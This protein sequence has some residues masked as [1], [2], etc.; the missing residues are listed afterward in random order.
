M[1]ICNSVDGFDAEI[2]DLNE[3]AVWHIHILNNPKSELLQANITSQR[4]VGMKLYIFNK[5]NNKTSLNYYSVTL[6]MEWC[7]SL[8]RKKQQHVYWYKQAI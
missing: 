1:V 5:N 7:A 6:L 4:K 2:H 3:Q 8:I